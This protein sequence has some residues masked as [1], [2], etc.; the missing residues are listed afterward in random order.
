MNLGHMVYTSDIPDWIFAECFG[1]KG[2]DMFSTVPTSNDLAA[3]YE[4]SPIFHVDRVRTPMLF[5][6]GSQDA[7]VPMSDSLR[8]V[9]TLKSRQGHPEVRV[10]VFPEDCHSLDKPQTEF[11]GIMNAIWWLKRHGVL[12]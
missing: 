8:Y 9:N 11:E 10:L 4:K 5:M 2:K 1:P 6:L 7:R 3:M 12:S